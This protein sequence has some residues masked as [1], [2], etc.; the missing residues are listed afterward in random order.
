M[1]VRALPPLHQ[2]GRPR[3]HTLAG[4]ATHMRATLLLATL[5]A[6]ALSSGCGTYFATGQ[7]LLP[8][9]GQALHRTAE[10]H[11]GYTLKRFPSWSAG[12]AVTAAQATLDS[13]AFFEPSCTNNT[14]A[15]L[16]ARKGT[17][18]HP[19]I[20]S[21]SKALEVQYRWYRP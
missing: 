17:G 9:Q 3:T 2:S 18:C 12:M 11:I 15:E 5:P 20:F 6:I 13:A 1:F 8:Y 14:P 16:Q 4:D 7:S 19:K 10:G 21:N